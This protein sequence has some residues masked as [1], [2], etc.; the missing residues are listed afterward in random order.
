MSARGWRRLI[1]AVWIAGLGVACAAPSV[2][3]A[4]PFVAAEHERCAA[5]G[6]GR[7]AGRLLARDRAGV[8]APVAG[9]EVILWPATAYSRA[10]AAALAAGRPPWPEGRLAPYARLTR[11][12]GDGA[13]EFWGLPPCRYV[14]LAR[15]PGSMSSPLGGYAAG[16]GE[17]R[18]AATA[19]LDLVWPMARPIPDAKEPGTPADDADAPDASTSAGPPSRAEPPSRAAES[20][21]A[22]AR[23]PVNHLRCAWVTGPDRDRYVPFAGRAASLRRRMDCLPDRDDP[24]RYAACLAEPAP[25]PAARRGRDT[26][27]TERRANAPSFKAP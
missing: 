5:G 19:G 21:A 25:S 2:R 22:Y 14:A 1:A 8:A 27:S 24:G 20:C 11:T 26:G 16:E 6:A 4:A 7:L 18:G 13:F 3:A 17:V 23:E 10:I 9:R 15:V 12:G